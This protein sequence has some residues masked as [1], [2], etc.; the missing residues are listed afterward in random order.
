MFEI[1]GF[2]E[3]LL[4]V[5]TFI[6]NDNDP[7]RTTSIIQNSSV[8]LKGG[9]SSIA[10]SPSRALGS[11]P[12]PIFLTPKAPNQGKIVTL[13]CQ[14][15]LYTCTPT[16]ANVHLLPEELLTNLQILGPL[17]IYS[18][19]SWISK[20]D[21]WKHI[22]GNSPEFAGTIG[23]IFVSTLE[24]WKE[25]PIYTLQ[26]VNWKGI[27]AISAYTMELLGILIALSILAH[28]QMTTKFSS[29]CKAAVKS[30]NNLR[31]SRK[32]IKAKSRDAPLLT[33]AAKLLGS[34]N[35]EVVW[36]KGHPE[37]SHLVADDLT[38]DM[39]GNHLADGTAAGIFFGQIKFQ[40]QNLY[41]NLLS[42]TALPTLDV[43]D[44]SSCLAPMNFWCFGTDERHL[45]STFITEA[46]QKNG[47]TR[48]LQKRDGFRTER[49]NPLQWQAYDRT[50]MATI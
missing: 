24:D 26:L 32:M 11:Y 40:Y 29:D 9:A 48:Y 38:K 3:G 19:G 49:E 47:A 22:M 5:R 33:M 21:P 8:P 13:I 41:P 42:I 44:L 46:V 30:V 10:I 28:F 50:L 31:E 4:Y 16:D 36:I 39:W 25:R 17:E 12:R 27:L 34:Q 18:V 37:K 6:S 23:L 43:K 20:G 2:S 35:T 45:V 7:I 15:I 1:Q 14:P